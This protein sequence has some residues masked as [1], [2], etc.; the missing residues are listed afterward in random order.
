[1]PT[2]QPGP[3]LG[4]SDRPT[5]SSPAGASGSSTPGDAPLPRVALASPSFDDE[6]H[7]ALSPFE[8]APVAAFLP[9]NILIDGDVL[10]AHREELAPAAVLWSGSLAD[11]GPRESRPFGGLFDADPRTWGKAGKAALDVALS[12]LRPVATD[13]GVELWIRPHCRH[14]VPDQ[15]AALH[16]ARSLSAQ[17]VPPTGP[18]SVR[19]LLDTGSVFTAAMMTHAEDHLTRFRLMLELW[20]DPSLRP[21]LA[22]LMPSDFAPDGGAG[23]EPE[24]GVEP[25]L[26]P[27]DGPTGWVLRQRQGRLPPE[28]LAAVARDFVTRF[29]EAWLFTG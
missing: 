24:P 5:A 12:R 10:T 28:A 8:V 2:D 22:G 1:M 4:E 16:L 20:D 25:G 3:A 17:G 13:L 27:D 9:E 7:W 14:A 29:P 21:R 18:G 11:R 15:Q 6:V 23:G 19:I 26:A